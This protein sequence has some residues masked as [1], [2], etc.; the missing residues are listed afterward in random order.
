[1]QRLIKFRAYDTKN[2]KWLYE[3]PSEEYMLDNDDCWDAPDYGEMCEALSFYPH[4]PLGPD[5]NG[6]VVYQQFTGLL[7]KNGKEIYEGDIVSV[8]DELNQAKIGG[9]EWNTYSDD[10]Y[11]D[12]LE[13][14]MFIGKE[15]GDTDEEESK[16]PLSTICKSTGVSYGRGLKTT[17]NTIKIIGNIFETPE[18]LK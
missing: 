13:C 7:D 10:E 3:V 14:W 16:S 2:K 6:R 15:D 17:K 1:M 8:N 12:H 9:I 5:F 4:K 11:V 18:L